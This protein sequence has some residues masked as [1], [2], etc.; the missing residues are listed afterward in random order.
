LHRSNCGRLRRGMR[1]PL[2]RGTS[3][4]VLLR[5]R[6]HVGA[7]NR[8]LASAHCSRSWGA[9]SRSLD[10]SS[11][12]VDEALDPGGLALAKGRR[13]AACKCVALLME[14][15][16]AQR[17]PRSCDDDAREIAGVHGRSSL[18]RLL[19]AWKGVSNATLAQNPL[20]RSRACCFGGHRGPRRRVRRWWWWWWLLAASTRN[21]RL[22]SGRTS[23][24]QGNGGQPFGPLRC[25]R[26]HWGRV[27]GEV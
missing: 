15:T 16:A 26:T 12:R 27:S 3:L 24:S 2:R 9:D 22:G 17:Q 11:T 18:F 19:F 21:L 10:D 8:M 14:V 7:R 1:P 20:D 13:R 6:V 23:G 5:L 4:R 25:L